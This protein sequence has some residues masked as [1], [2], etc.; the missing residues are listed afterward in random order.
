M[1]I[2]ARRFFGH[3][4]LVFPI[5]KGKIFDELAYFLST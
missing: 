4:L 3:F 1:E 2:D 5:S